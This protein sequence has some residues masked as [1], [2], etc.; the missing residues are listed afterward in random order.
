MG[1]PQDGIDR[2][3]QGLKIQS[4]T[5]RQPW[6][7]LVVENGGQNLRIL[8]ATHGN[9]V[10]ASFDS[11]FAHDPTTVRNPNPADSK[12]SQPQALIEYVTPPFIFDI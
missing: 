2:I 8:N 5:D 10:N 9:A 11:Y 1:M 7:R 12:E 4:A 3:A 6:D